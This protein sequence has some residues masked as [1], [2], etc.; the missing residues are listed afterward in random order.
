ML[1]LLGLLILGIVWVASA[2]IDNDAASM[3]SLYGMSLNHPPT[4]VDACGIKARVLETFVMLFLLG[5]LILGIVW[6]ASA[7]IDNDA[8]SM[9]SLYDLWEFYL[10]YLYSCISLMGGLLLLSKFT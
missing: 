6:V 8:A 3:E 5:L 4:V 10:P 9:E 1:F 2:L 7:L